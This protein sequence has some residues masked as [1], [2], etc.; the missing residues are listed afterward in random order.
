MLPEL[1][2]EESV[3][4]AGG[5]VPLGIRCLLWTRVS[6]QLFRA[7]E[8]RHSHEP[9]PQGTSDER[10]RSYALSPSSSTPEG[11]ASDKSRRHD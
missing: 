4:V 11:P 3:Q 5:K 9:G 2:G 6:P 1:L 7:G 8:G 10:A